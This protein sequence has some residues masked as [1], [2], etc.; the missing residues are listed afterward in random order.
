MVLRIFLSLILAAAA[1]FCVYGLVAT[2]EPMPAGIQWTWRGIYGL[3]LVGNLAG[4]THLI[5]GLRGR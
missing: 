1:L 3:I 2:L 4:L 5:R